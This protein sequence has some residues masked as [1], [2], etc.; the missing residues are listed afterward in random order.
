VGGIFSYDG[1][2]PQNIGYALIAVEL[3]N[4]IN[5]FYG[6]NI[7]QVNMDEVLCLDG[8]SNPGPPAFA[9]S[10]EAVYTEEAFA[11]LLEAFPVRLPQVHSTRIS[12]DD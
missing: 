8:C 10:K 7:P 9:L 11:Q 1:V 12:S 2:H 4:V 5:D 6:T 3:I